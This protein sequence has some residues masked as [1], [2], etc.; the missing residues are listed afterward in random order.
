[1]RA[2]RIAGMAPGFPRIYL[3]DIIGIMPQLPNL[4]LAAAWDEPDLK[5]LV[6]ASSAGLALSMPAIG[7][8]ELSPASE[9]EIR[10]VVESAVSIAHGDNKPLTVSGAFDRSVARLLVELGVDFLSSPKI[11]PMVCQPRGVSVWPRANLVSTAH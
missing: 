5:S 3:S 8:K 11:W 7:N 10:G 1:M 4:L 9:K 6:G 2:V